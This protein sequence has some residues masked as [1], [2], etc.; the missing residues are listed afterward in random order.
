VTET[1]CRRWPEK[2]APGTYRIV[3]SCGRWEFTGTAT[4]IHYA[5]IG[6]DDSP[7]DRH[8]VAIRSEIAPRA[9]FRAY[10]PERSET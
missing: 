1:L 2:H 9:H 7:G 8:I 5:A 6:H 4:E 10:A 3:C